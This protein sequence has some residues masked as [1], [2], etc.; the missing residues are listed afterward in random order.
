MREIIHLPQSKEDQQIL[1]ITQDRHTY[2]NRIASLASVGKYEKNAVDMEIMDLLPGEYK[3]H[4]I[5]Q[6]SVNTGL[7]AEGE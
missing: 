5:I 2:M 3:R 6:K 1:P 7:F 4:R